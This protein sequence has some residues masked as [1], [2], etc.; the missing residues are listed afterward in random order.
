MYGAIDDDG[1]DDDDYDHV[2]P[3]VTMDDDD[4]DY[5][6]GFRRISAETVMKMLVMVMAFSGRW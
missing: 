6:N 2:W 1:D 4:D 3:L 5:D